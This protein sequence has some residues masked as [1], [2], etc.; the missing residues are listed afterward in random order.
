MHEFGSIVH[1]VSKPYRIDF[2]LR[3]HFLNAVNFEVNYL[4][5][6]IIITRQFV[7]IL[8]RHFSLLRFE[9]VFGK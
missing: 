4:K 5:G 2:M 7:V 3:E 8:C 1:H 9:L 6:F